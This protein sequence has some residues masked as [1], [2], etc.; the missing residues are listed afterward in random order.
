MHRATYYIDS[1]L[2]EKERLDSLQR[3]EESCFEDVIA[4]T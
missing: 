4:S 3:A 1:I 2:I